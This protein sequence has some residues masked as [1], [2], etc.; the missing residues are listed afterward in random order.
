MLPGPLGHDLPSQQ[1]WYYSELSATF[2]HLMV[3]GTNTTVWTRTIESFVNN[4]NTRRQGE[5]QGEA[6]GEALTEALDVEVR[7]AERVKSFERL[8][9]FNRKVEI[10]EQNSDFFF[11]FF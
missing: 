7:H 8:S 9:K 5:V 6:L 10:V 2:D 1:E 4:S 11:S 3:P